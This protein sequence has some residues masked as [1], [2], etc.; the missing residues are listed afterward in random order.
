MIYATLAI[1]LLVIILAVVMLAKRK[2]IRAKTNAEKYD[3]F[4]IARNQLTVLAGIPVTYHLSEINS[5]TFSAKKDRG[6]ISYIGIMRVVKTNGKKSRPFLFDSSVVKKK[7]VLSNS[8]QDI[9]QTIQYL[10]RE[11]ESHYIRCSWAAES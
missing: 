6:G 11:L 4:G 1:T 8:K 10:M 7:F 2:G 3:I 5:I 9:E